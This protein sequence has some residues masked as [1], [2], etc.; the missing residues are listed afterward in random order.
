MEAPLLGPSNFYADRQSFEEFDKKFRTVLRQLR[1]ICFFR[2]AGYDPRYFF[3]GFVRDGPSEPKL[4]LTENCF[5][6]W[7]NS[8]LDKWVGKK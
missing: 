3:P 8:A 2:S 1:A 7:F 5:S 4:I 6:G